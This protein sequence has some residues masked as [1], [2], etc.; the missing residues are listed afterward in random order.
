MGSLSAGITL[1]VVISTTTN[2][3]RSSSASLLAVLAFLLLFLSQMMPSRL[4]F[5]YV[6]TLT[7]LA[8]VLVLLF[9]VILI[10]RTR[11]KIDSKGVLSP[12]STYL[13]HSPPA[14]PRFAK[15][16]SCAVAFLSRPSLNTIADVASF[17]P[18]DCPESVHCRE[19]G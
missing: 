7:A 10:H 3:M 19:N 18:S 14:A 9:N 17:R 1:G 5:R 8:H 11:T 4:H 16:A 6:V 12:T 13:I 15:A 2:R